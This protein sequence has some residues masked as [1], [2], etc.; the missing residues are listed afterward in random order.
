M[1]SSSVLQGLRWIGMAALDTLLPPRCLVCAEQVPTDGTLCATCFREMTLIGPP[2]CRCCGV[3]FL[4]SGQGA[5]PPEGGALHCARCLNNPPEYRQA[6]AAWLY[7]KASR[8]LLLPL[9]YADRTE[10][11][12]PLARQMAFAGRE[13]LARAELLVPVPL[14]YRR[15]LARK[16]NQ[17]GLLAK[18]LSR[19]SGVP[20]APDLLR[21]RRAT[22]ALG[23][24]SAGE[25]IVALHDA[26]RLA[27][28]QVARIRGRRL[29]LV[30]DVMTSGATARACAAVLL[31]A[32][33]AAVDVL[34]AARVPDP[35]LADDAGLPS[36]RAPL[37]RHREDNDV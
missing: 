35:A 27:P 23:G 10:L 20:W 34:A 28:R 16:Y 12:R 18:R 32:G 1:E 15:L 2:L 30:D 37:D 13:M 6:R 9:K 8:R 31:A 19:L 25:R 7:D 29:L 36:S 22:P 5:P 26:F 17:A 33:A 3:P 21:R 24:L 11:A 14:H 4:H